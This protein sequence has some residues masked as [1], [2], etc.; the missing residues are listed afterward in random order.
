MQCL[1]LA[2]ASRPAAA[3]MT[4]MLEG[5]FLYGKGLGPTNQTL[6]AYLSL[7]D[8]A[9]D[10]GEIIPPPGYEKTEE[11]KILCK[12]LWVEDPVQCFRRRKTGVYN[13]KFVRAVKAGEPNPCLL[14]DE[15]GA[16]KP[17]ETI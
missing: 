17:E 9:A 16:F 11:A 1:E 5:R 4:R 10:D 15:N 3:E 6:A 2:P 7:L 8:Y 12:T 14:P 13:P